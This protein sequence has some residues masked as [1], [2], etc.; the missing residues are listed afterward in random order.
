MA[1]GIIIMP[2][3]S[4]FTEAWVN[5][6]LAWIKSSMEKLKL[7]WVLLSFVTI[8]MLIFSDDIYRI[9]VGKG[10]VGSTNI[11]IAMAGFIIINC[12]NSIFSQFLNG[13]GKIKLQFYSAI[14]GSILNIP[15]AVFLGKTWGIPGVILSSVLLGGINMI[16]IIIQYNKIINHKANGIWGK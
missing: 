4:A 15:L 12:W 2:F 16:W 1:L 3:W 7:L 8:T 5:N 9:W 6:D 13:I 11:S 10:I 14:W